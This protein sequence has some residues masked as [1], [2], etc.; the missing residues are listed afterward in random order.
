VVASET[1]REQAPGFV[2]QALDRVRVKGKAASV[3]V[4]TPLAP[5]SA[6]PSA[7]QTEELRLWNLALQAWRAQDWPACEAA[8]AQLQR[9]SA[10]KALYRLYWER[11]ATQKALPFDPTWDGSARFDT[12]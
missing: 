2:W 12:K 5:A 3:N 7:A 1:T 10:E 11:V 9:Q 8:L 4:F 6:G